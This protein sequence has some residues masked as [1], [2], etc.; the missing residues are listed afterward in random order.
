MTTRVVKAVKPT[1]KRDDGPRERH[2][3]YNT[4]IDNIANV[5]LFIKYLEISLVILSS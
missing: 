4:V 3:F 2:P 5:F 1:Q